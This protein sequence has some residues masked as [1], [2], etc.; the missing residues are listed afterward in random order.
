MF[1][2]IKS[3]F[4]AIKLAEENYNLKHDFK[5]LIAKEIERINF[6]VNSRAQNNLNLINAIMLD[7]SALEIKVKT[8]SSPVII[9]VERN[10]DVSKTINK[11]TGEYVA[12]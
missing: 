4:N 2:K 6:L 1:K 3:I 8:L 7:V 10:R 5:H 11:D 12:N 9:E